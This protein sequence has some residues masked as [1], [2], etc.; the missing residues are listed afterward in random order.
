M[1][2]TTHELHSYLAVGEQLGGPT[3]VDSVRGQLV[4]SHLVERGVATPQT[5]KMTVGQRLRRRDW[6]GE[7]QQH[8]AGAEVSR[9]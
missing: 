4:G 6:V 7:A 9:Q 8:L 3:N 1:Q 2:L 5:M